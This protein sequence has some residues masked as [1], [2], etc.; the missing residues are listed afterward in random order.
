MCVPNDISKT[1]R[2]PILSTKLSLLIMGKYDKSVLRTIKSIPW[3][4]LDIFGSSTSL[5]PNIMYCKGRNTLNG[6]MAIGSN[7]DACEGL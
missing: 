1:C 6:F 7:V 3:V 4:T 5:A 2:N